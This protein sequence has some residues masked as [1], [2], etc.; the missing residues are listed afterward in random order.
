MTITAIISEYNPFHNGHLYQ[1]QEIKKLKPGS[2]IVA[3]MSGNYVQRGEPA[4]LEKYSRAKFAVESG[5]DLVLQLPTIYSL[6]SAEN[7]ALGG[8]KIIKAINC[9]DYLSFGIETSNFEDLY[10]T[11]ETQFKNKNILKNL[12]E[13]Y[14][15]YGRSY[16]SAYKLA[17]IDLTNNIPRN[18]ELFLSNNILA[19]E[20]LKSTF[21][22]NV[23]INFLPIKRLGNNYLDEELSTG[24]Y[25]SATSIRKNIFDNR[26]DEIGNSIPEKILEDLKKEPNFPSLND[27]YNILKYNILVINKNC[28]SITG[29]ENGLDNLLYKNLLKSKTVNELIDLCISKRYKKSRIQRYLLNYLL[30]IDKNFIDASAEQSINY[31]KVLGFNESGKKILNKIKNNSNISLVTKIKDFK[32]DNILDKKLFDLEIKSTDLYN[33]NKIIYKHEYE[34]FPYIKKPST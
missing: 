33:I 22:L 10:K 31:I 1:I 2:K 12:I 3:I 28:S 9:I 27:Y 19:L 30:D 13:K 16:A 20:Y 4:L 25:N 14:M 17:T 29:Y 18:D 24:K 21:K 26:I 7:F 32:S 6:Q 11:A 5:V 15:I 8:L 23:K 34:Y